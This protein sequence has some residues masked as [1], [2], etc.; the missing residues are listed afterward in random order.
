V[1]SHELCGERVSVFVDTVGLLHSVSEARARIGI[2]E[3][4]SQSNLGER[5]DVGKYVGEPASMAVR[6]R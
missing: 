2:I 3:R 1:I 6:G 5:V 4:P